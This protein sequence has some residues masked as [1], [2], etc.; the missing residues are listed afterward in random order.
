MELTQEQIAAIELFARVH[1]R[2]WKSHL[3][4]VWESGHYGFADRSDLL[5]QVRNNLG[6]SWLIKFRLPA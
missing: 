2:R 6:P 3:L 1:G 5:Q 4:R